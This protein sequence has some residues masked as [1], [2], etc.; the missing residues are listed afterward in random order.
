VLNDFGGTGFPAD[1]NDQCASNSAL[2]CNCTLRSGPFA[3]WITYTG[4][5]QV[6]GPLN[7]AFGCIPPFTYLPSVAA[8][9]ETLSY[10]AY[11][12]QPHQTYL[13]TSQQV[14]GLPGCPVDFA[15]LLEGQPMPPIH[16]DY[17]GVPA[18]NHNAVHLYIGGSM[19]WVFWAA[20]DPIFWVHHAYV[21]S[22]L[23]RWIRKVESGGFELPSWPTSGIQ[24][25]H[26]FDEAL[27]PFLPI[28]T[29]QRMFHDSRDFGYDYD[30][31][32]SPT[33]SPP[34]S[35]A[36]PH[37]LLSPFLVLLILFSVT[38]LF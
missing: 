10:S 34:V 37:A 1:A 14:V 23:E 18:D 33:P 8:M 31:F 17:A 20:N 15:S 29:H 27:A 30:I 36:P 7:R 6:L 24:V 38:F 25:G 32:A 21:D 5:V 35:S 2:F 19:S 12:N 4:D 11:S 3:N 9:N 13:C 16:F 26:N 22:V 28:V